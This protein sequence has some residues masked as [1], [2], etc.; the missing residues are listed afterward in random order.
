MCAERVV[1]Y[2]PAPVIVLH[3]RALALRAYAV[4]PVILVGKAS[5]RPS[6]HRDLEVLERI[7]HISAVSVGVGY[8]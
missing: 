5:A 7:E 1:L 4:H 2:C 3:L 8:L 6:Q